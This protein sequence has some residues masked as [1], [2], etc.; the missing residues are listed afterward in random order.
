MTNAVPHIS[1]KRPWQRGVLSALLALLTL[2]ALC[3]GTPA[4]ADL[5]KVKQRGILTVA[6]YKN[7]APFSEN[8]SGIDVDIGHALAEKLGVKMNLLSFEA[9]EELNDD[10]RNMVWKGHYLGYGPADLMMHVPVDRRLMEDNKRVEIFAPYYRDRVRLVRDTRQIPQC[11][12]IDCVAGKL[13]G[14]ERV[15]IASVLLLGEENGRFRNDIRIFDKVGDAVARLK[16]GELAAVLATQSEIESGIKGDPRFS[17][18]DVR[19][20]RLPSAGWVIGMSVKKESTEL[21]KALQGAMNELSESGELAA[22]FRK[23]GVTPVKP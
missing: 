11:D 14:V 12:A 21:A 22:I 5:A 15:S 7:M 20:A 19:F 17:M 18:T 16:S 3:T 8:G 23:Y 13:V 6:V 9:G 4:R 10:L 2:S 1:C